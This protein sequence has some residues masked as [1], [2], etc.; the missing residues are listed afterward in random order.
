MRTEQC[1]NKVRKPFSAMK[2]KN[3]LILKKEKNN[4]KHSNR[5]KRHFQ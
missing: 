1:I 4:L 5:R 3:I 2:F